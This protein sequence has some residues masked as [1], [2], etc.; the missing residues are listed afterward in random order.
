[1]T[2]KTILITGSNG[3]VG[4]YLSDW[5]I[6]NTRFKLLLM[7]RNP[8]KL[9]SSIKN[10]KRVNLL[11][12]D[13]R[14]CQKF[15]QEICKINF[16]IHTATAWGDPKR[17]YEV[18]IKAF[19]DLLKMLDEKLIERILYFSTASILDKNIELMREALV[20]GTEYIQTKYE[21]YERL[22]ESTFARKT[23][24]IF[25]TLV[26][27][28]TFSNDDE[29][30]VSYLTQGLKE[31]NRWLWIACFFKINSK[32]HFIHAKDIA[33]VCGFLIKNN[34]KISPGFLKFVLGQKEISIDQ[35]LVTLLKNS[36]K[37]RYFSIPLTK[38]ILKILLKV[39]PIQTTPWDSFSINKYDFNHKPITNPESFG[40]K[41]H[42]KTLN[43]ILK[44]SK[45]PRCNKN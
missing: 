20:Y 24:V 27:G 3:C 30:P 33:Q 15:K 38:V 36:N 1:M 18:N 35:A 40:L 11:T 2:N 6:K 31:A 9:Q 39:L 34:K 29:F 26:F 32:F 23:S 44:L 28:G 13:I 12:C 16:L 45:L 17:A 42:G 43:K 19:E 37:K 10:N 22:K 8:D 41:S 14:E 21:C 25:P 7:V 4:Q 5:F